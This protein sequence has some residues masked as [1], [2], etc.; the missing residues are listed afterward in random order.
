ME[1]CNY[2]NGLQCEVEP[3]ASGFLATLR[4]LDVGEILDRVWFPNEAEANNYGSRA[5]MGWVD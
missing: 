5:V 1:Y 2:A 3:S 4:K